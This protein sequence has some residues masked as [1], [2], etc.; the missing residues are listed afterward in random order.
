[1]LEKKHSY[2]GRELTAVDLF[3]GGGGISCGLERAGFRVLAG[4]DNEPTYLQSYK[5][6]FPNSV[7]LG[8]DLSEISA[9]QVMQEIDIE[10][11]RLGILV[12]G[13]PCQGFSKNVP[14]KN[15]YMEDPKNQLVAAFLRFAEASMPR[16]ILM[17]NVAEMKEGFDGAYTNLLLEALESK[18]LGYAVTHR[19]LH[20]PDFG[21]P[22]RR[23]RAFFLASRDGEQVTLPIPTH[24]K[25]AVGPDLFAPGVYVTVWD[26]ISDLPPLEHGEGVSPC[27]YE[28][29]PQNEFQKWARQSS[30][31]VYNHVARKL[32]PTQYERLSFLEPGQGMRDLPEHLRA[33]SG[34]S[35]AYGRLTKSM[36]APTITRWVFHP[37]SGRFGHPVQPRVI[38][39]REAA[40]LQAFPDSFRFAGTYIQQSH[41][42]GNAVPP[43]L[44]ERIGL[45]VAAQGD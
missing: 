9:A 38:T 8:H 13:P 27:D 41:Q 6:N 28:T 16:F 11:G 23:R 34:Y 3:C 40:R 10:R 2:R 33:K 20:A 18:H 39:I 15:R 21:V 30:E 44:A 26:A 22:Q 29:Q 5:I 19:V 32:Q 36:V 35:G 4:V 1:M 25:P 14:R 12:G 31:T 42:V 43:L 24:R 7:S 17:E 37:G 45:A